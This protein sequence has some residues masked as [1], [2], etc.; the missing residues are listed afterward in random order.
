MRKGKRTTREY[1]H[2][3]DVG[4]KVAWIVEKRTKAP[5]RAVMSSIGEIC[6]RRRIT[7]L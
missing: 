6:H 2:K 4:Q 1:I 3:R 7:G 5:G